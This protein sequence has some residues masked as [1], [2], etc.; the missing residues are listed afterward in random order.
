M[1]RASNVLVI[2][3]DEKQDIGERIVKFCDSEPTCIKVY[4]RETTRGFHYKLMFSRRL[5][6]LENL[7]YRA[8]LGDDENRIVSDLRRLYKYRNPKA[9][10]RVFDE[11]YFISDSG[12]VEQLK[13]GEWVEIFRR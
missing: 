1:L 4:R 11:K 13:Y 2:D 12:G 3:V 8:V 6:V 10:N 7:M 5:T 9:I